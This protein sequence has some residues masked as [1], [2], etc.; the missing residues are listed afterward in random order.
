MMRYQPQ[1]VLRRM[2][3]TAPLVLVG[4]TLDSTFFPRHARDAT[5]RLVLTKG[6]VALAPLATVTAADSSDA[7]VSA[8]ADASALWSGSH[9]PSARG[10]A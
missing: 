2:S 6:L 10:A 8:L 3:L 7:A 1:A 4:V 5:S 9:S